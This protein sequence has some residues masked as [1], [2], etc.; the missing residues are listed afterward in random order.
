MPISVAAPPALG[1]LREALLQRGINPWTVEDGEPTPVLVTGVERRC[2]VA[3]DR[4]VLMG[5]PRGLYGNEFA[6][7][8]P[9]VI[10]RATKPITPPT[11]T[12]LIAMEASAYGMGEYRLKEIESILS[13][14]FTGFSA[15]QSESHRENTQNPQVVIHTGFWGCGAYGGNRVLMALLQLMAAC[16]AEVDRLVF[17]THNESGSDAFEQARRILEDDLMPAKDRAEVSL[18]LRDIQAMGFQWGVSDGN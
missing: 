14:A 16:L 1:S 2:R 8:S 12:N 9:E 10:K 7:A 6:A 5:R 13:T 4:D 11:I 18:L 15:A 17:H 3:T